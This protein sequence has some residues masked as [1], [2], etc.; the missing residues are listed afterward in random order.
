M[1]LSTNYMGL[2]LP[3]PVIVAASPLSTELSNLRRM[4][5]AGAGAVV[6]WSLFEEQMAHEEDEL[7]FY[8]QYGTERFPESLTYF[9]R[10][11]E[12]H[13]GPDEYLSYIS[14]AKE[15][16]DIPVIASL[17]G[18]S[19]G[20][21]T[22]TARQ[23]QQAGADAL[24]LNIYFLPTNPNVQGEEVENAYLDALEAVRR[25]ISMPVAMKLSPF[26]SA[27]GSLARRFGDAGANGLVLFNR[28]YQPDIDLH[29]LEVRPKL[30]LS[31]REES[32][33]PMRWIAILYGNVNCSL[34]ASSGIQT[35]EDVAKM[36]LSGADAVQ[37]C[38]VLLREGIDYLRTLRTELEEVMRVK[39]YDSIS[40]MKGVMSSRTLSEPAAFERANYMKTLSS[41]GRTMTFE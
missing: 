35:G 40:Q 8:M 33:L 17:N 26:F 16:V 25:N 11:T 36:V 22:E 31:T 37:V 5:D 15:A 4:E 2:S 27:L 32:R 23:I 7:D 39:H 30:V 21:W 1:D 10:S 19:S 9:P 24:E 12:Y 3:N 13:T 18:V 20:G 29:D 38:S 28:F 6:L 14:R 34:A 41:F